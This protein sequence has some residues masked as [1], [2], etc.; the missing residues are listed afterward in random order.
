MQ[1]QPCLHALRL[2]FCALRF[3][4]FA[5]VLL[6][7]TSCSRLDDPA[8]LT[9]IN[10]PEPESLDPA[11][12]TA[13]AFGPRQADP[14]TGADLPAELAVEPSPGVGAVRRGTVPELGAEEVTHLLAQDPGF[15]RQLVKVEVEGR[16]GR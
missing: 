8:D 10:G 6:A 13:V 3:A 9:I 7:F 15:R 16:H 2:T 5:L 11:L 12:V 1:S 4:G 14:A